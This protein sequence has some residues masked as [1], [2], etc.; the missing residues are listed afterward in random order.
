MESVDGAERRGRA[1]L[2]GWGLGEWSLG[3]WGL[4]GR[5]LDEWSLDGWAGLGATGLGGAGLCGA[6]LCGWDVTSCGD[7]LGGVDADATLETFHSG[8]RAAVG[9]V[10]G[11]HEHAGD[12]EFEVEAGGGGTGH[13]GEARVCDIRGPRELR[14]AES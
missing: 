4:D 3:G 10:A 6:G 5:S 8:K 7:G 14:G 11:R 9:L 2:S 12:H 1:R 13:L